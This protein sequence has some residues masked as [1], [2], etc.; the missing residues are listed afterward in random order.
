M[1]KIV[2][3]KVLVSTNLNKHFMTSVCNMIIIIKIITIKIDPM[4]ATNGDID[5]IPQAYKLSWWW[6]RNISP[7]SPIAP[8]MG[9]DMLDS[10]GAALRSCYT[11]NARLAN[12]VL[13]QKV[14][15]RQQQCLPVVASNFKGNMSI[16][17]EWRKKKIEHLISWLTHFLLDL[18]IYILFV[19]SIPLFILIYLSKAWRT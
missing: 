10:T 18:L 6:T 12:R 7:Q 16:T 9:R 2:K 15:V 19:L 5:Y 11:L 4:N 8:S 13:H 17:R 14:P 3:S 1:P